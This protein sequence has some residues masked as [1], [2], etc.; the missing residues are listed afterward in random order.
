MDRIVRTI[1]YRYPDAKIT[2]FNKIAQTHIEFDKLITL[3]NKLR[4]DEN[5][6]VIIDKKTNKKRFEKFV[7]SLFGPKVPTEDL[8]LYNVILTRGDKTAITIG[9]QDEIDFI[10]KH[11]LTDVETE[12]VL[13][14]NDIDINATVYHERIRCYHCRNSICV[15]CAQTLFDTTLFWCPFCGHHYIFPQIAKPT[16][17]DIDTETL[18]D[19]LTYIIRH[20]KHHIVN[21]E[22]QLYKTFWISLAPNVLVKFAL[23]GAT[24]V[25]TFD[26]EFLPCITNVKAKLN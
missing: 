13:C 19:Y 4:M 22:G 18:D 2:E 3:L 11:T 21:D 6:F 25:D 9:E 12:C 10:L 8:P 23:Y 14:C 15:T 26:E 20:E 17:I 1:V 16:D 7:K 5:R 24:V